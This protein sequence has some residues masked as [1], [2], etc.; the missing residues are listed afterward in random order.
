MS[1]V[2]DMVIT[3]LFDDKAVD[4]ISDKTGIDFLKVSDDNQCGGDKITGFQSYV[5]CC[6]ALDRLKV[7]EVIRVFSKADF[8]NPACAALA[9]YDEEKNSFNGVYVCEVVNQRS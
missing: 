9:I 6:R 5:H 7:A 8:A 1:N 3:C 4:E 2:T